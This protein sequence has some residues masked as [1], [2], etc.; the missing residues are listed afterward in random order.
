MRKNAQKCAKMRKNA[1]KWHPYLAVVVY[2]REVPVVPPLAA[3]VGVERLRE[4]LV[5]AG[6][7]VVTVL[8]EREEDRCRCR[9]RCSMDTVK[10]PYKEPPKLKKKPHFPTPDC[11]FHTYL[12]HINKCSIISSNNSIFSSSDNVI[13]NNNGITSSNSNNKDCN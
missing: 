5:R 8:G 9:C 10:F 7:E 4:E 13:S 11:T 3:E 2:V 12:V 1:Q 6:G